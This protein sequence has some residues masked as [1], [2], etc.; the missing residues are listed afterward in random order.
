MNERIFDLTRDPK[1]GV[2]ISTYGAAPYVHLQLESLRRLTD[3][4]PV[5]VVD[6]CSPERD[7]LSQICAK[8]GAEF[9][10]SEERKGHFAGDLTAFVFGMRWAQQ[11]Q[12]DLLVKFS[13]RWIPLVR[14]TQQLARLAKETQY[15]TYSGGCPAWAFRFRTEALAMHVGTWLESGGM[16]PV[17]EYADVGQFAI[18]EWIVYSAAKRVH[19]C[20][21]KA[22]KEY[23]E[24]NPRPAG[25]EWFCEWP[26]L[27]ES[28][29]SARADVL[30]HEWAKPHEYER[31]LL[32]W[33]GAEYDS[34]EWIV[35]EED[36]KQPIGEANET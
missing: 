6:D 33:A 22:N 29:I 3:N 31:A 17:K 1:L 10:S 30:W 24:R 16:E 11:S 27:G 2:V 4:V 12:V 23:L 34:K 35:N 14:W 25:S 28:R 7:R 19:E 18:V 20:S 9:V 13:R 26:L 8:Y 32:Q 5:L 36:A 15:A 21:C